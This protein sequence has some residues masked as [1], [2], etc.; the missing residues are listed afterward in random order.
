M[1]R[2]AVG[3][4]KR[5]GRIA[6]DGK[7]VVTLFESKHEELVDWL[8]HYLSCQNQANR[9]LYQLMLV[10]QRSMIA[11]MARGWNR[12][13]PLF[14]LDL[15]PCPND[16]QTPSRI[17]VKRKSMLNSE[18]N[19]YALWSGMTARIYP[20][21]VGTTEKRSGNVAEV[22]FFWWNGLQWTNPGLV[23]Q[24][25]WH[26]WYVLLNSIMWTWLIVPVNGCKFGRSYISIDCGEIYSPSVIWK[27]L[28]R[29]RLSPSHIL[30]VLSDWLTVRKTAF[31]CLTL[32]LII[33]YSFQI[34]IK[35]GS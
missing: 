28:I 19:K 33:W 27:R 34:K 7:V 26:R 35:Y 31:S 23:E 8:E 29:V 6:S 14:D 9:Q 32:N 10:L 4:Q 25:V 20:M 11:T 5:S 21:C 2:G 30:E 16:Y 22:L 17:T 3:L 1:W 15:S 12:E 13:P 24:V 18:L